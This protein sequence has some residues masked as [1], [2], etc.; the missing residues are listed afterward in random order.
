MATSRN[1]ETSV[2]KWGFFSEKILR[3]V[4]DSVSILFSILFSGPFR[5][6]VIPLTT[7][8][9]SVTLCVPSALRTIRTIMISCFGTP[10]PNPPLSQPNPRHRPIR[11]HIRAQECIVLPHYFRIQFSYYNLLQKVTM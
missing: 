3:N 7:P 10:A 1:K 4:W 9:G 5:L 6:L 11:H 8:P 2:S